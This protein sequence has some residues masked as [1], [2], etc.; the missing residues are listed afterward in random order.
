LAVELKEIMIM[1]VCTMYGIMV[2]KPFSVGKGKKRHAP[3]T[4]TIHNGFLGNLEPRKLGLLTSFGRSPY[5]E[6]TSSMERPGGEVK[7]GKILEDQG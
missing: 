4:V 1:Y 5:L 6:E 2:Q 3:K 7:K